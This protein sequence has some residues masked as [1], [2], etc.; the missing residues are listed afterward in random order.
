MANFLENDEFVPQMVE[1]DDKVANVNSIKMVGTDPYTN[2]LTQNNNS[3]VILL[4]LV[5]FLFSSTTIFNMEVISEQLLLTCPVD[6]YKGKKHL[7]KKTKYLQNN[8]PTIIV[9]FL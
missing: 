3:V 2:I 1:K 7:K 4:S 5:V 6:L 8:Q 9:R